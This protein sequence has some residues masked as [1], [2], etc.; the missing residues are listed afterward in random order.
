[1]LSLF[2]TEPAISQFLIVEASPSPVLDWIQIPV[3][4]YAGIIVPVLY[5]AFFFFLV[6]Y[7]LCLPVQSLRK[8]MRTTLASLTIKN[9]IA[10]IQGLEPWMFAHT[11][12]VFLYTILLGTPL[13]AILCVLYGHHSISLSGYDSPF[14]AFA[15]TY[16]LGFLGF[17][18]VILNF[19]HVS[20]LPIIVPFLF[21]IG[22]TVGFWGMLVVF[23]GA[24]L[25]KGIDMV[26]R[27]HML[28]IG[29]FTVLQPFLFHFLRDSVLPLIGF[30]Q[31][32][33]PL[34]GYNFIYLIALFLPCFLYVIFG[35]LL[36]AHFQKKLPSWFFGMHAGLLYLAVLAAD[37]H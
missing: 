23:Y 20:G 26:L 12:T 6:F 8:R 9:G 22:F 31:N 7:T 19:F 17:P 24:L 2:P 28:S 30:V 15:V 11:V 13:V 18:Y 35:M 33:P 3:A 14:Q 4:L 1:M 10:L 37:L 5:A 32:L 25:S 27:W 16:G 21:M 36:H 34:Y 29:L